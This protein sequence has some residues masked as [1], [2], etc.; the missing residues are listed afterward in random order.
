MESI[1]K[2]RKHDNSLLHPIEIKIKKEWGMKRAEDR[3]KEE[4]E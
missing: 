3:Q 1:K 4:I 2:I